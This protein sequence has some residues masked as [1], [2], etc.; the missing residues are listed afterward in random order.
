SPAAQRRCLD[1]ERRGR[2]GLPA[3]FVRGRGAYG[4]QTCLQ[5]GAFSS[6]RY[7]RGMHRMSAHGRVRV[8]SE[9]TAEL[10]EL[11]LT[12]LGDHR[13]KDIP[14]TVSIFRLGDD[15]SDPDEP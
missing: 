14:D 12:D 8:L 9:A 2:C 10:V 1:R 3:P 5:I 11:A 4:I 13:F 15:D 7:H 6:S